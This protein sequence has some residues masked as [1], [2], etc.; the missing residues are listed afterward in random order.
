MHELQAMIDASLRRA[1]EQGGAA[2]TDVEALMYELQTY[3]LAALAGPN[4][5]RRLSELSTAQLREVIKRLI[6]CRET[7]P[8]RDPG[9]SDELLLKLEELR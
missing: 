8:G 6:Y 4:C 3:G 7:Y 2:P 5:R 9:I 1:R